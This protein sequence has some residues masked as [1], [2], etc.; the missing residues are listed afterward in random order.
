MVEH[1]ILRFIK[2]LNEVNTMLHKQLRAQQEVLK[3]Q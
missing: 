1:I 2:I 3:N